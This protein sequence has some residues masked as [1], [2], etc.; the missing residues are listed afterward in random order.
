MLKIFNNQLRNIFE[1]YFFFMLPMNLWINFEKPFLHWLTLQ[2]NYTKFCRIKIV[3]KYVLS[4]SIML[5][6]IF[7]HDFFN[8]NI[9]FPTFDTINIIMI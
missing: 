2:K 3:G 9:Y 6:V 5:E 7:Q 1:K 4:L 8:D